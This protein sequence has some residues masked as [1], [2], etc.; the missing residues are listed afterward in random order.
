[1]KIRVSLAAV[2]V[3]IATSGAGGCASSGTAAGE[4][5]ASTSQKT[6]SRDKVT[7][8]EILS[9]PGSTAYDL[10]YKLRPDWL[11]SRGTATMVGGSQNGGT[12]VYLDGVKMGGLDALRTINSR[13]INGIEWVPGNKAAMILSDVGSAAI[14]GA[15]VLTSR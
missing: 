9:V 2:A 4:S 14:V 11:R 7:S 8:E 3:V 12:L 1:M 6:S 10:V 5:T 13:G 15:I